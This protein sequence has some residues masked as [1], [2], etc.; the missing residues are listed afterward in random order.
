MCTCACVR[1]CVPVCAHVYVGSSYPPPLPATGISWLCPPA[2]RLW[3]STIS[4]GLVVAAPPPRTPAKESRT[5]SKD[6]QADSTLRCAGVFAL[7]C[8]LC[9]SSS[10]GLCLLQA[11]LNPETDSAPPPPQIPQSSRCILMFADSPEDSRLGRAQGESA[12]G[13]GPGAEGSCP[14]WKARPPRGTDQLRLSH[15]GRGRGAQ[16]RCPA[17]E[18]HTRAPGGLQRLLRGQES[19]P[20]GHTPSRPGCC[21]LQASPTR[22]PAWQVSLGDAAWAACLALR[23]SPCVTLTVSG[24]VGGSAGSPSPQ[25]PH[26]SLISPPGRG[27]QL[28]VLFWKCPCSWPCVLSRRPGQRPLRLAGVP[29]GGP[30]LPGDVHSHTWDHTLELRPVPGDGGLRMR[31]R[32]PAAFLRS[33]GCP[34]ARG[35]GLEGRPPDQLRSGS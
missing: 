22:P 24:V 28:P 2:W 34:G 32:V 31:P 10:Q 33:A 26:T 11:D 15:A 29:W 30:A 18:L 35:R 12:G 27:P 6:R 3:A 16:A 25:L 20:G 21:P 5:Q 7:R 8:C 4:S 9:P 13:G 19:L 17:S 23:R 1:A 14:E